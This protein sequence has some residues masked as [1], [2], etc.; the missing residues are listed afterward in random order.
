MLTF[1]PMMD[2]ENNAVLRQ[3]LVVHILCIARITII[4][5][6]SDI[7]INL[8]IVYFV[9]GCEGGFPYLIAGKYAEDFGLV[10]ESCYPYKGRDDPCE[11]KTCKR[12]YATDY[13]YVGGY[14]GACNEELMM[15]Q[16]VKNGPIAV[17]F[18]VLDD[19]MAYKGGIYHHTG[20]ANKFTPFE[21]TNHAVLVVGYGRDA[22]TGEKYW[23][24]KN[25]WGTGWGEQGYFRIRRGTDEVAIE[26][27][28]LE[29]FPIYP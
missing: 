25:S 23:T 4:L 2:Q 5:V 27:M 3:P 18:E 17:G 24:V 1:F 9:A 14:Y 11:K 13:K 21:L 20:V 26:S 29:S 22:K 8:S 12:Y 10:E 16:L 19:F 15:I 28:A 7:P 6:F